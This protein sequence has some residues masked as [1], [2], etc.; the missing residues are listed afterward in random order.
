ME[1]NDKAKEL[2][3][4][5]KLLKNYQDLLCDMGEDEFVARGNGFCDSKYSEEFINMQIGKIESRI[6]ALES[7]S[8]KK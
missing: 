3:E 4:L 8:N 5:Y 6:Q 1:T 7:I 2:T